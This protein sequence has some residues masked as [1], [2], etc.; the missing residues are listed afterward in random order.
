MNDHYK[1]IDDSYGDEDTIPNDYCEVERLYSQLHV[2]RNSTKHS[3]PPQLFVSY[4]DRDVDG[5][6]SNQVRYDYVRY[7]R[8]DVLP[9]EICDVIDTYFAVTKNGNNRNHMKLLHAAESLKQS[10]LS[11]EQE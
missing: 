8:M 3:L 4:P 9:K 1:K 11:L 7:V 5:S 6:D 10:L 2:R